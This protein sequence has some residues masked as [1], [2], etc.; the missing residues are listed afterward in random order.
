MPSPP[1]QATTNHVTDV[2]RPGHKMTTPL[3]TGLVEWFVRRMRARSVHLYIDA[4]GSAGDPPVTGITGFRGRLLVPGCS[5]GPY[6]RSSHIGAGYS[7]NL[8]RR[9]ARLPLV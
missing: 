7:R 3:T 6:P 2:Q 4:R 8:R 9:H 1:G 5:P